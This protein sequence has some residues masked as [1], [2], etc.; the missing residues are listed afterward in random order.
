MSETGYN[1]NV[2]DICRKLKGG[3]R[4]PGG[5]GTG[6]LGIGARTGRGLGCCVVSDQYNA[7]LGLGLG[8]R[9]GFGRGNR[10]YAVP[11]VVTETPK[12]MLQAQKE[13]LE[14]RLDIVNKQLENN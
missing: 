10:Y 9:R 3:V 1:K 2:N 6:P 4:M 5:D 14:R 12:E 13:L 11:A 8:C 7:G